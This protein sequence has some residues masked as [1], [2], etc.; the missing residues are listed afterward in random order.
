MNSSELFKLLLY[1]P[2]LVISENAWLYM[3]PQYA[4][5]HIA[6]GPAVIFEPGSS[7]ECGVSSPVSLRR[8]RMTCCVQLMNCLYIE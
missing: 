2:N 8:L 4:G 5:L 7:K 6:V 3:E 1:S